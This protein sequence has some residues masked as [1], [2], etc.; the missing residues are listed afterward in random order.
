MVSLADVT[1]E[2][3]RRSSR[4][5]SK[6]SGSYIVATTSPFTVY[7]DGGSTA[8][9]ALMIAGLSYSVDDTGIYLHRQGQKP[10]CIPTA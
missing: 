9:P 5:V 10:L 1:A 8:V 4:E 3:R 2:A 7:L 6:R